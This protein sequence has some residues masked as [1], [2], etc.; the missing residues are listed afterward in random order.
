MNTAKAEFLKT[1]LAHA[2]LADVQVTE[3]E[4]VVELTDG[5]MIAAPL[6]SPRLRYGTVTE[7][8]IRPAGV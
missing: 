6:L 7:R 1:R 3:D 8:Q 4:L 2:E 5:R